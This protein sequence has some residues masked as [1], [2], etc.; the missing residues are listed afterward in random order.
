MGSRPWLS[1]WVTGSR[2]RVP[3]VKCGQSCANASTSSH[4]AWRWLPSTEIC[5][6]LMHERPPLDLLQHLLLPQGQ[7]HSPTLVWFYGSWTEA[8]ESAR[9]SQQK[10]QITYST[11]KCEHHHWGRRC[12]T[13]KLSH[14][15]NIFIFEIFI[16]GNT[17]H[18]LKKIIYIYYYC[19]CLTSTPKS[20]MKLRKLQRSFPHHRPGNGIF[21]SNTHCQFIFVFP[22]MSNV[23]EFVWLLKID[24]FESQVIDLLLIISHLLSLSDGCPWFS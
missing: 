23:V 19:C 2:I 7:W 3:A 20:R 13:Q 24:M 1:A 12:Y 17:W 14:G 4:T 21:S 6:L 10:A 15:S 9:T 5:K 8:A 16:C 11:E 22:P 18:I